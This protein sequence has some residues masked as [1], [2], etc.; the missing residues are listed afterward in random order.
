MPEVVTQALAH[1]A[2]HATP[3]RS[4][5]CHQQGLWARDRAEIVLSDGSRSA[6]IPQTL[7]EPLVS[8][9]RCSAASALAPGVCA[10]RGQHVRLHCGAAG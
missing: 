7:S 2:A 10:L 6:R 1:L 9:L 3:T 5:A 4:E 8:R